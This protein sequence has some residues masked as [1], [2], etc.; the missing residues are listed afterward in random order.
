MKV[1]PIVLSKLG[2]IMVLVLYFIA[3]TIAG[4]VGIAQLEVHFD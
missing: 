3:I 4:V 2:R 1:G